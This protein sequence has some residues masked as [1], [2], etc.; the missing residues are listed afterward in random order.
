MAFSTEAYQF[1][2]SQTEKQIHYSAFIFDPH[3]QAVQLC[4]YMEQIGWERQP[5]QSG[6]IAERDFIIWPDTV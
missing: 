2:E 3:N 4:Y 5:R 6:A 1:S